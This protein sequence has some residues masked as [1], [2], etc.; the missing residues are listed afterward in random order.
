MK[1]LGGTFKGRI[2]KTPKGKTTR[3][4][5]S[6]LRE[7]VFNIS[8]NRIENAQFLDLFAGSG[9]MGLEAISRG[10]D[11]AVFIDK[12]KHAIR[13]LKPRQSAHSIVQSIRPTNGK[14]VQK[15]KVRR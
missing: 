11:R 7:S 15:L 8:Q 2:I 12:D 1:I 5:L 6:S 3:P 14:G 10:A 4:T 13:N 9:A